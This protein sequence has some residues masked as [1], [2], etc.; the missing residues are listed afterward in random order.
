MTIDDLAALVAAHLA[1]LL[2]PPDHAPP[3]RLYSVREA[4]AYLGRSHHA[5][6]RLLANGTLRAVRLD[7]HVAIDKADL[8]GLIER[9]KH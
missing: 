7:R 4:A 9:R 2:P 1:R 3:Q 6:Y 5:V 8:D